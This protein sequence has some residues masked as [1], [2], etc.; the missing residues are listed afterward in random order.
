MP[1]NRELH[2]AGVADG[3]RAGRPAPS[4]HSLNGALLAVLAVDAH[5]HWGVARSVPDL[6]VGV[7]RAAVG[8]KGDVLLLG[9]E[10]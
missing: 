8:A 1:R 3:D 6:N 5:R 4:N 2:R 9:G 7:K 10:M